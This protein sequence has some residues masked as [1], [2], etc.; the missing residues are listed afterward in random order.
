VADL[1]ERAAAQEHFLDLCRL[2]DHPT[3]AQDDPVGDHFAFEKGV[4]KT[5]GGEGFADVWKK[6]FFA[7]EYKKKKR[8]LDAALEQLSRYAAALEYP[9]LH[10]A[11][12]IDR[13]IIATAWTNTVPER[14][15]ILLED[16]TDPA[17]FNL[18]RAV[19]HTPEQ[20]RPQRTRQAITA[21]AAAQFVAVAEGLQK[22]ESDT[23]AIA[24][25][26]SQLVFCFFAEDVRLLP[27]GFFSR[28]LRH[29]FDR[30]ERSE[31]YLDRLFEAMASGGEFD[32]TDIRHFN[33][34]LFNGRGAFRLDQEELALL[35]A[36][37]SLGWEHIDP[38]IFGT[39]FERFL[40]PEK[41]AQIGAHYTDTDKIMMIVEP[42]VLRPL[43]QEWEEARTRIE[44]VLRPIADLGP[45]LTRAA[46]KSIDRRIIRLKG[47]AEAIR[48]TFLERLRSLSILDP[49]CGSGNFLYLALQCVKDLEHRANLEC[50]S[51]GL[52]SRLPVVGPEILH[53][54]ELN[55][56]AAELASQEAYHHD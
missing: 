12:D 21:E 1:T 24:H 39:L 30:P 51:L 33:G 10:V 16:L 56:H 47:Q 37:G 5:G 50:E 2:F 11:C 48:E 43:R 38:T 40:D 6:G 41:R 27:D 20:L 22:R 7:W 34:G 46:A 29:A 55:R 19:F 9:P 28:V 54:I 15:V 53:G 23:E 31:E 45:G 42:V 18:L 36:V 35:V 4:T 14:H 25:F 17:K 13:F 3:P 44:A 52:V 32:L 26:I 49:A 8:S